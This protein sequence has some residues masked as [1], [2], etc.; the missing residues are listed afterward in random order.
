MTQAKEPSIR[1]LC[2]AAKILPEF[3]AIAA[4]VAVIFFDVI[5]LRQRCSE[6]CL[7]EWCQF[8]A[9]L[10]SGLILLAAAVRDRENDAGLML[11]AILFLDMA[12]REQD[13]TLDCIFH[14][15]WTIPVGILTV[16]C[17]FLCLFSPRCRHF[18]TGENRRLRQFC[19]TCDR[20]V[21]Y[22]VFLAHDRLQDALAGVR[23]WRYHPVLQTFC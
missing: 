12:I 5:V 10:S 23:R 2:A 17:A 11:A 19:R 7:V 15:F 18:R 4:A 14:G 3:A 13:A 6:S 9:I 16:F 21:D 22:L 8:A 20:L 1:F